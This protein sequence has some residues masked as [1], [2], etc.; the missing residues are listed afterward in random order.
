MATVNKRSPLWQH[1]EICEDNTKFA[2]CLLC[3]SKISR[4]GEGKKAGTSAMK[5]HIKSKH[6]NEYLNLRFAPVHTTLRTRDKTKVPA[7]TVNQSFNSL[8]LL[9]KALLGWC[10]SQPCSNAAVKGP[11]LEAAANHLAMEIGIQNFSCSE[12]WIQVFIKRH[13]TWDESGRAIVRVSISGSKWTY[14]DSS[15]QGCA[16]TTQVLGSNPG[17]YY[18]NTFPVSAPEH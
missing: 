12:E 7:A 11:T 18:T 16:L 10:R 14:K 2:V 4:G 17:T 8:Y 1:F 5:N 15:G 13:I 3:N 6:A 9:E